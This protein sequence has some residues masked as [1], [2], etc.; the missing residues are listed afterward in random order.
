[1]REILGAICWFF[2]G[3]RMG[4]WERYEIPESEYARFQIAQCRL[5]GNGWVRPA[6]LSEWSM[7]ADVEPLPA[8]GTEG[9]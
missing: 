8:P 5:C 4:P 6:P 7:F 9:E 3:H 2:I 1:M